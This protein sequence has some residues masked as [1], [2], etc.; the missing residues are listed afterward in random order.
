[1]ISSVAARIPPRV[2]QEA[3]G[4]WGGTV[5]FCL[6]LSCHYAF[7]SVRFPLLVLLGSFPFFSLLPSLS[8]LSFRSC[9]QLFLILLTHSF[10]L[11]TPVPYFCPLIRALFLPLFSASVLVGSLYDVRSSVSL[12]RPVVFYRLQML[13]VS[14][15]LGLLRPVPSRSN[16]QSMLE[17]PVSPFY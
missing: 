16:L 9:S 14:R 1:M 7:P 12:S 17:S 2:R 11:F 6:I 15:C 8:S 4:E 3:L 5:M 13:R 10:T